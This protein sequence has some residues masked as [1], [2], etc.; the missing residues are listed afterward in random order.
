M[1]TIIKGIVYAIGYLA[2]GIAGSL[3]FGESDPWLY[4]VVIL[5][6]VWTTK[7]LLGVLSGLLGKDFMER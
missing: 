7:I 3:I 2:A 5:T 4:T 6:Y 1:N